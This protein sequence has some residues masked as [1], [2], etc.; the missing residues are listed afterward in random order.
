MKWGN[1]ISL[2]FAYLINFA[3]VAVAVD[4][5]KKKCEHC[6]LKGCSPNNSKGPFHQISGN[7]HSKYFFYDGF[8]PNPSK[9]MNYVLNNKKKKAL[10]FWLQVLIFWYKLELL[11]DTKVIYSMESRKS[12]I[13]Y[14][15]HA[16]S[17]RYTY[18][19]VYPIIWY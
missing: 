13:N 7:F 4:T 18:M 10:Q 2:N 19:Y 6:R 17:F 8:V 15:K 12:F 11:L 16:I 14:S 5:M 1:K 9:Y 3:V